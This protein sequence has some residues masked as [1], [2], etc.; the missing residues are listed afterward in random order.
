LQSIERLDHNFRRL[1]CRSDHRIQVGNLVVLLEVTATERLEADA[2]VSRHT[3]AADI[4]EKG[5]NTG[6]QCE[7]ERYGALRALLAGSG[8]TMP[9]VLLTRH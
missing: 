2:S 8:E 1:P 6:R 5:F 9:S 7:P 3:K 4:G